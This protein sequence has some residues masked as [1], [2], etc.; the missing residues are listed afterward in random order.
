MVPGITDKGITDVTEKIHAS[1]D[2][3]EDITLCLSDIHRIPG[4][5]IRVESV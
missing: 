3:S 1:M 4:S 5:Q 2:S